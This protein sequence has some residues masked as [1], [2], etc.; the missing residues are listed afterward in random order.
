MVLESLVQEARRRALR[1]S[2]GGIL[3]GMGF[4]IDTPLLLAEGLYA[5]GFVKRDERG[6]YLS[7]EGRELVELAVEVAATLG[8]ASRFPEFD[9][10]A[11][12][13]AA[14]YA[15]YDWSRAKKPEEAVSEAREVLERLRT[16]KSED[17]EAFNI[18]AVVLPR[19]Y[20][21][22]GR[23]SALALVESV[24]RLRRDAR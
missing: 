18:V 6:F 23:Y 17:P 5:R 7:D 12:V 10:G 15:L 2:R 4:S 14:L 19:F 11:L 22:D 8:E 20:Y 21:E 24:L 9:G 3:K 1:A 16:L 13:G